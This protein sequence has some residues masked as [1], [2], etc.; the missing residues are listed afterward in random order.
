MT[1]SYWIID[2]LSLVLAFY[3]HDSLGCVLAAGLLE[4]VSYYRTQR[5]YTHLLWTPNLWVKVLLFPLVALVNTVVVGFTLLTDKV[6]GGS[7]IPEGDGVE[8]DQS[9]VVA[10]A[11]LATVGAI[12]FWLRA[13]V[14]FHGAYMYHLQYISEFYGLDTLLEGLCFAA[15]TVTVLRGL[16]SSQR[17][18]RAVGGGQRYLPQFVV[19]SRLSA[20][21]T[22]WLG[23]GFLYQMR[24]VLQSFEQRCESLGVEPRVV[25]EVSHVV[26]SKR[27]A[28][29]LSNVVWLLRQKAED[30]G[31]GEVEVHQLVN[32]LSQAINL[33]TLAELN[34]HMTMY[35]TS[36]A[37]VC[38]GATPAYSISQV[39]S[40]YNGRNIWGGEGYGAE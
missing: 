14:V 8:L 40:L 28:Q 35:R 3:H 31:L 33:P 27:N 36:E 5:F 34:L 18:L 2:I 29:T 10:E 19:C 13:S 4:H 7:S 30:W 24:P 38:G 26:R 12:S 23:G 32:L 21:S 22:G 9:R 6:L 15:A 16:F 39:N 17:A 1:W 37:A 20:L 11:E 25:A